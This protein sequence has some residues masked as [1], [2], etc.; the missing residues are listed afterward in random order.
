MAEVPDADDPSTQLNRGL[1]DILSQADMVL[2]AGE[3]G[4][5]CVKATTEHIADNFGA[6]NLSKLV[7]LTDCISPVGGFDAQYQAFLSDMRAR[8]L[9]TATTT[10]VLADVLAAVRR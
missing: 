6:A 5:H 9:S 8:G 2:I 10:D 4:S 1:I 3:A 7:L